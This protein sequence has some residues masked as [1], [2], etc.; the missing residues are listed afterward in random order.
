MLFKPHSKRNLNLTIQ[1]VGYFKAPKVIQAQKNY[2]KSA[3]GIKAFIQVFTGPAS[4]RAIM[5]TIDGD[6]S[7]WPLVSDR[8]NVDHVRL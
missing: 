3:K 7:P 6:S 4:V 1:I 8:Q 2:Y 5:V